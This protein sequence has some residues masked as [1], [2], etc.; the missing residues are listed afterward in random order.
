MKASL[1]TKFII[2]ITFAI[3]AFDFIFLLTSVNLYNKDKAS[4]IYE[5]TYSFNR[6]LSQLLSK[7]LDQI[8]LLSNI[9]F[10]QMEDVNL[11][12]SLA[13]ENIWIYNSQ[14]PSH[15]HICQ[16]GYPQI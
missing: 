11:P 6:S 10:L 9:D 14:K 5:N 15:T 13:I 7:H 4:Y 1:R 12:K 2:F 3:V 8:R 16:A